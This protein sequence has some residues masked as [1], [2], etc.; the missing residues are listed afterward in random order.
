MKK[1]FDIKKDLEFTCFCLACLTGKTQQEMS[2]RDPQ[3]CAV[4]QSIIETEYALTGHKKG[5]Q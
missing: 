3:Y 2:S 4:C 1:K 5:G